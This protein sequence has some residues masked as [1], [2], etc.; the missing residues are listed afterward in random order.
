MPGCSQ[1][2]DKNEVISMED[3]IEK[4]GVDSNFVVLD[5]RTEPELSG[6]LSHIKGIIH[7]P[8]HELGERIG[9]LEK[10]KNN[11]IG[12]ICRTA[13]RST[14]ATRFLRDKGFNA[15]NVLGGMVEYRKRGGR[16]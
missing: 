14:G 8:L 13:N 12:V 15:K 6:P 2:Q 11:E 1:M 3:F 16:L 9:E 10:Y 4:L 5:I 7:I